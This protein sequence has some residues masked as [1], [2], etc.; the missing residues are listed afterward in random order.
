MSTEPKNQ[1]PPILGRVIDVTTCYPVTTLDEQGTVRLKLH[2][3]RA[4]IEDL[5]Q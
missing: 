1:T 5:L 3:D 4:E 2:S